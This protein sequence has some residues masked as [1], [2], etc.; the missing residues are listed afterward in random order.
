MAIVNPADLIKHASEH[1]YA[2]N[3][4][5]VASLAGLS[6]TIAAAQ[7]QRAS[8]ILAPVSGAAD[9]TTAR[10]LFAACEVAASDAPTPVALLGFHGGAPEDLAFYINQGCNALH[11]TPTAAG[12][13]EALHQVKALTE[14]A[15]QCGIV[16]G[17]VLPSLTPEGT[18][19]TPP[20]K[21]AIAE[22][23][24]FAQRSG[25]DFL[26]VEW[27]TNNENRKKRGKVDYERLKRISEALGRILLIRLED[28]P[29][30]EQVFR[31][32][33]NGVV[34][35]YHAASVAEQDTHALQE[36][37]KVWGSAGRAAEVLT[38]CRP[39]QAVVQLLEF[40]IRQDALSE[41]DKVLAEGRHRL[42]M[43]PG[44]RRVATGKAIGADARHQYCWL[45]TFANEKVLG[46]YSRHP[47]QLDFADTCF[48]PLA[49]DRMTIDFQM[50]GSWS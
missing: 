7:S 8:V 47:L 3:V 32:I 24:A 42:A 26:E 39:W 19:H 34:L 38:H 30:P 29:L 35:V 16:M 5:P 46:F 2:L 9:G 33:E 37:F 12:F 44:V 20:A 11:V 48:R 31:L 17:A 10:A 28:D 36:R 50:T 6:A 13:P 27:V 45:I 23:V 22:C 18:A 1:H 43:I 14:T 41:I 25:L 4:V 21:P 15:M 40:N 49:D